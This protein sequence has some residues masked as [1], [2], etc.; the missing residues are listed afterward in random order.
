MN[1]KYSI[2]DIFTLVEQNF[3]FLHVGL[4]LS[5]YIKEK[6]LSSEA[7]NVQLEFMGNKRYLISGGRVR[8]SLS[9]CFIDWNKPNILGYFVEWNA[10]RGVAMAMSEGIFHNTDFKKYLVN[11]LGE[12]KQSRFEYII[13]F[14][15]NVL[16]HNIENE[17]RLIKDNFENSRDDFV[18]HID[19][20]GIASFEFKYNRDF[21]EKTS[22]PDDYGFNVEIRF[23]D[24]KEGD[25]F[26]DI[27]SE[28]QLFMIT[29]LCYNLVK[30]YRKISG[31]YSAP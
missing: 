15:R 3:D 9:A 19:K 31:S 23:C 30:Y 25:R 16:S 21:P 8:D 14:I 13:K 28:W 5:R 7:K 11:A 1:G 12:G 20:S 29:E 6:N 24:L 17:I 10:F 2:E 4:F 22:F 18:R 26:V 27:V